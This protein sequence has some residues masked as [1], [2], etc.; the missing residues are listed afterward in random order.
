MTAC[1]F[2]FVALF[3]VALAL[4]APVGRAALG[5]A[6]AGRLPPELRLA[7]TVVAAFWVLAAVHALS[8]GGFTKRF[9]RLGNRHLTSVLVGVT[10]LGALMNAASSSP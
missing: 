9:P 3:Q 6:N 1:G 10:A 2:L 5:G 7:T 8:R 4:G